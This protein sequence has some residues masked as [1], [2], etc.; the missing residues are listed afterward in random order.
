MLALLGWLVLNV[1]LPEY[2]W[3]GQLMITLLFLIFSAMIIKKFRERRRPI[4]DVTVR[5]WHLGAVL[6]ATGLLLWQANTWLDVDYTPVFSLLIGGFVLS[7]ISGM[8]Y[9]IIPFLV[10]FHLNGQG[11]M[12]VP[13]MNEMISKK[14]AQLQFMLF[15]LSVVLFIAAFWIPEVVKV[16]AVGL[17]LSMGL[18]EYNLLLVLNVYRTTR[19]QP[20]EFATMSGF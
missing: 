8:L 20:P 19:K 5:Y 17:F 15:V 11:Y 12:T 13:T 2:F 3:L 10:W 6:L 4:S 9:K 7:I 18:L 16:G 14:A 1:S